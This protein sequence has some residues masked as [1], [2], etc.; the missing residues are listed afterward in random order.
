M[1]LNR[2]KFCR[3]LPGACLIAV[4][5]APA[6]APR[7]MWRIGYLGGWPP[8]PPAFHQAMERLGYVNGATAIFEARFSEGHDERYPALAAE[9][10]RLDVDVLVTIAPAAPAAKAATTKIPIVMSGVSDPVGRGLVASLAHP[11]GNV[12]GIA[13][14]ELD[15]NAKRIEIL[16]GAVP[17]ITRVLS[18][19]N[20]LGWDRAKLAS[21]FA[22]QDAAVGAIGI[23]VRRIE[24]DKREEFE[25]VSAAIAREKPDA[26]LLTPVPITYRLRREFAALALARRLPT[27]GWHR[28][29]ALAE[30][31]MTYGPSYD[32]IFRLAATYVDKVLKGANPADLPVE[33]PTKVELIINAG[34][35]KSLDIV[36]PQS[37]LVRANEVIQ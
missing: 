10:V 5:T 13:N 4:A 21:A 23:T 8:L 20:Y 30:I 25:S 14:L 35:A 2:R 24:I 36:L 6:Q 17:G 28:E 16:K 1:P 32:D 12:T 27:I 31:L 29:Q 37:L 9:L 18:V 34:T 3:S 22:E 15:L 33:Q 11:G 19:T 7:R 26:L